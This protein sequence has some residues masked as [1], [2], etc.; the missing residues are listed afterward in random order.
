MGKAMEK[1]KRLY[2]QRESFEHMQ[3]HQ[4]NLRRSMEPANPNMTLVEYAAAIENKHFAE[5]LNRDIRAAEMEALEERTQEIAAQIVKGWSD[6]GT[7]AGKQFA[8][9][10]QKGLN[11]VK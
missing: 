9:A 4:N 3:N 1:L 2:E 8:Q 11:S 10:F 5:S 6:A 7:Q